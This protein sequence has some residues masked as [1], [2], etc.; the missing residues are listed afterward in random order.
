MSGC[1]NAGDDEVSRLTSEDAPDS[2]LHLLH[3]FLLH[4]PLLLRLHH[5]LPFLSPFLFLALC[6]QRLAKLLCLSP[7]PA[8]S[9]HSYLAHKRQESEWEWG[10]YQ[11]EQ[12]GQGLVAD[13]RTRSWEKKNGGLDDEVR[14][15]WR[16]VEQVEEELVE[17]QQG[18]LGL[19]E[20]PVVQMKGEKEERVGGEMKGVDLTGI[21]G[22]VGWEVE[23]LVPE[24]GS[25]GAGGQR[26]LGA[27]EC[28]RVTPH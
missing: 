10:R 20:Q 16:S 12:P 2:L 1:A 15:R 11:G 3:Q 24:L 18:L 14:L 27:E 21:E 6:P 28:H 7:S 5:F 9:P 8:L 25:G 19:G 13:E 17:E 4:F 26:E 22:Q 23:S